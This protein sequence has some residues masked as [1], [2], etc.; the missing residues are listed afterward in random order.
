MATRPVQVPG[1]DPVVDPIDP[2]VDAPAV[3]PVEVKPNKKGK[4]PLTRDDY[5][6][7]HSSEVDATTLK[8]SV[9]CKDGWV[10]PDLPPQAAIKA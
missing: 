9:L 10:V 5:A 3:D 4:G 6:G 8:S 1:A 7:M 2:V